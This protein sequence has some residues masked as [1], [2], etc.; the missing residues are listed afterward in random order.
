MKVKSFDKL[1]ALSSKMHEESRVKHET[2][3]IKDVI[4]VDLTEDDGLT[5]KKGYDTRKKIIVVVGKNSN[6]DILGTLLINHDLPTFKQ[7]NEE[8]FNAQYVLQQ[9]KYKR[10]LKQDSWLDCTDLFPMSAQKIEDRKGEKVGELNQDDFDRV[11]HTIATTDFIDPN[12]K[13]RFNL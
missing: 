11:K 10:F 13:I 3:N 7:T 1:G 9:D 4:E 2:I 6:G 5:L 12:E 8:L